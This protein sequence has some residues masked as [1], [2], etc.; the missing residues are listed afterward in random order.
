MRTTVGHTVN[1]GHRQPGK[2]SEESFLEEAM[3]KSPRIEINKV[4]HAA[5]RKP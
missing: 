2:E 3:L 4:V 1:T 5:E